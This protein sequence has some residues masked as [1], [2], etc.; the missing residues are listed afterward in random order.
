MPPWHAEPG[1]GDFSN[2][3]RLT[4]EE[5]SLIR[6]WVAGGAPEGDPAKTPAMPQW[7]PGWQ[8]GTPDLV[9]TMEKPYRLGAEGPDVYRNF[10]IRLPLERDRLVRAV[11]FAPG[12]P[13][14]VHH[15]FIRVDEENQAQ[16]LEGRDGDPGFK[17]M[18]STARMPGGQFL[19]WNPGASPVVSPPGLA[20][21]LPKNSDL[22]VEMHLNRTGKPEVIQASVG[23]YFP[24]NNRPMPVGCSS[25][26]HMPLPPAPQRDGLRCMVLPSA[27]A[28]WRCIPRA[29]PH[30]DTRLRHSTGR[31][32]EWLIWIR[33]WDFNWQGDYRY[34]RP[35]H[36]PKAQLS[37]CNSPMTRQTNKVNPNHPPERVVYSRSPATKCANWD[38][39][40]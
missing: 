15:A 6:R 30:Q 23:I 12:N 18:I 7:P 11:E 26:V 10:L 36:L 39:R 21:R 29:L 38:C 2:E 1:Y 28:S 4:G 8:L 9:V 40:C 17:D 27:M 19:T 20:W 35:V 22:V 5:L 37:I 14:A 25:W 24:T 16:R 32:K 34:K 31:V 13:R 33:Q 3:R